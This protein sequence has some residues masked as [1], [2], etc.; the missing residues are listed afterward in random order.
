MPQ[1]YHVSRLPGQLKPEHFMLAVPWDSSKDNGTELLAALLPS[2]LGKHGINYVGTLRGKLTEDTSGMIEMLAEFIRQSHFL[3][4]PSRLASCFACRTLQE[5]LKFSSTY[6]VTVNE[7]ER[8][9]DPEIWIVE[10][11]ENGFEADMKWL[12]VGH[13]WGHTLINLHNYWSGKLSDQPMVEVL[14]PLPVKVLKRL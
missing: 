1:Y 7:G 14:L 9:P 11:N 5:A 8:K 10:S 2:G 4:R 3:H 12:N 6:S 13:M